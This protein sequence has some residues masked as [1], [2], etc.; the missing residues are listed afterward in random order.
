[1]GIGTVWLKTRFLR[2]CSK[3]MTGLLAQKPGCCTGILGGTV[4]GAIA[5]IKPERK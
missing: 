3:D 4:G 1:M 5:V 2:R